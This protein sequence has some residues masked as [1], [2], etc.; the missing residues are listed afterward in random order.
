ME[1]PSLQAARLVRSVAPGAWPP[2]GASSSSRRAGTDHPGDHGRDLVPVEHR[3]GRRRP[4]RVGPAID[5]SYAGVIGHALAPLLAPIGFNWAD[6][7][8]PDPRHG[9]ARG[10]GGGAGH[11]STP[12]SG[13]EGA[14]AGAA[15]PR[16]ARPRLVAARPRCRPAR[17]VRVRAPVRLHL[18]RHQARDQ[19]LALAHR[20]RRLHERPGLRRPSPPTT[21]PARSAAEAWRRA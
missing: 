7:P 1:L 11:R 3:A 2:A 12:C 5:Y 6:R 4:A 8:R 21:S 17:L 9:G 19:L 20:H 14:A 10:G 15:R 13:G 16:P 18:E